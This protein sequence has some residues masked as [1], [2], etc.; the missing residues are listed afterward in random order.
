MSENGKIR[1][2]K[3]RIRRTIFRSPIYP[4][5]QLWDIIIVN[6]WKKEGDFLYAV[7]I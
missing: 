6:I 5:F 7:S 1:R 3:E 4:K 2:K